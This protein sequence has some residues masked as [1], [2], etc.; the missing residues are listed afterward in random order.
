[1]IEISEKSLEAIEDLCKMEE[2]H[3]SLIMENLKKR[4]KEDTIYVCRI[5]SLGFSCVD[6]HWSDGGF[7]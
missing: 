7:D 4:Y 6:L 3:E 2:L 1:M 5:H